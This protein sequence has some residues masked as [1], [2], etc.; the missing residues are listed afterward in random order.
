MNTL[1]STVSGQYPKYLIFGTMLPVV[2]FVLLAIPITAP[3]IPAN[4]PLVRLIDDLDRPWIII[5]IT[6]AVILLTGLLYNLN[7]LILGLYQ[8]YP[9]R[10]SLI[11][12]YLI[13]LHKKH[14]QDLSLSRERLRACVRA[15]K[16]VGIDS[17]LITDL[18]DRQ[19]KI[20]QN[21]SAR[22]PKEANLVLPTRLGN[23][24][25]A[26]EEYARQQYGM[27]TVFLWPRL[28]SVMPK[29]YSQGVDDAKSSVDFF[30]NSSVLS[31]C[32]AVQLLIVG[33]AFKRP[34][35]TDRNFGLWVAEVLS[36]ILLA[37]VFYWGAIN[38]AIEWGSEVKG[39]FDLYRNA[40]L[41]QLGYKYRPQTRRDERDLW[42]EISQQ[43][44]YGDADPTRALPLPYE[45]MPVSLSHSPANANVVLVYGFVAAMAIKNVEFRASIKNEDLLGRVAENVVLKLNMR[46]GMEYVWHSARISK[47]QPIANRQF[48]RKMRF[49][50]GRLHIGV[51]YSAS[52]G[53]DSE[54]TLRPFRMLEFQLGTLAK[55]EEIIFK[56]TC[57]DIS[58]NER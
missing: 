28:I 54:T 43:I 39:A 22:Y 8:G 4:L 7:A 32:V 56:C 41:A 34:F 27:D 31:G 47:C 37:Y 35:A 40:L 11:G 1:F 20:A 46:P 57:T 23:V 53:S 3:I 30:L 36:S 42:I 44:Y 52:G 16:R 58:V 9:F 50:L 21:L 5:S 55:G 48:S 13:R 15:G 17:T 51:E 24:V 49:D 19:M 33:V 38:R 26:S 10:E 18:Q 2:I 12:K 25:R 29:D 45:E 6:F 14:L